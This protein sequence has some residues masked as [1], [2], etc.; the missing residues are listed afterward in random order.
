MELKA[1]SSLLNT[2]PLVEVRN[3]LDRPFSGQACDHRSKNSLMAWM[4]PLPTSCPSSFCALLKELPLALIF[5]VILML[6]KS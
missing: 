5:F 3:M 4:L 2:V 1:C 6:E